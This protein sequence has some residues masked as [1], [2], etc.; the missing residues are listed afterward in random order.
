MKTVADVYHL[1][2]VV[3]L[4]IKTTLGHLNLVLRTAIVSSCR[5]KMMR[6]TMFMLIGFRGKN[7]YLYM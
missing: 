4:A 5:K 2:T 1:F 3:V 6:I 7:V